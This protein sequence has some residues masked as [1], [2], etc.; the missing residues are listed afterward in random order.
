MAVD[1]SR[2]AATLERLEKKIDDI[3][4]SSDFVRHHLSNYLGNGVAVTYLRDETPIYVNSNDFGPSSNYINGGTYETENLDLLLSFVRDDT[5][6]LD[7]G[8]NVGFFALQIARRVRLHGRVYAFEPHPELARLMRGSAFL[9]GL[10]TMDGHQGVLVTCPFGVGEGAGPVEFFYPRDHL[11]GGS[12]SGGANPT[13]ARILSEIKSIDECMGDNFVC[14]LVKIDVEGHELDVLRGMRATISRSKEIKLLF[15]KLGQNTGPEGEI[16]EILRG[17]GLE[18]Y[19]VEQDARLHRLAPGEL[20]SFSGYALATRAAEDLDGAKRTHFSIFPRQ[21]FV[22][23][24]H[25]SG[26]TREELRALGAES[27][28]LFHGPYWFLPRG[29]Y[30]L[31]F[32]GDIVGRLELTVAARFGYPVHAF[33]FDANT[34]TGIFVAEHDLIKF[35]IIGRADRSETSINLRELHIERLS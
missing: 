9:N 32:S 7:I 1:L 33:A 31:S 10:A 11:G 19:G 2:L 16:E 30:R 34:K 28:I 4:A 6:F 14:D 25:Q 24:P 29:A 3:A 13:S 27:E 17:L 8:A 26:C 21:L 18:L 15:E 35:E 22:P 5:V 20:R 23:P 12:R